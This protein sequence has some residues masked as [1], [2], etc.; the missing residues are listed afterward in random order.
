MPFTVSEPNTYF[1]LVGHVV[2]LRC[3]SPVLVRVVFKLLK[4]GCTRLVVG[5]GGKQMAS[6]RCRLVLPA[7]AGDSPSAA[8]RSTETDCVTCTSCAGCGQ[9]KVG[10]WY[11]D[12]I[13][14][15]PFGGCDAVRGGAGYSATTLGVSIDVNSEVTIAKFE[16]QQM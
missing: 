6:S 15:L 13:R 11:S 9:P 12:T 3:R 14:G 10:A 7:G 8:V 16:V 5:N 2:S 1:Q 4:P